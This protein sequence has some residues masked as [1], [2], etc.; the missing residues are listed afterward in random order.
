LTTTYM[1]GMLSPGAQKVKRGSNDPAP[2]ILR[3]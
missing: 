3:S 1:R 2:N